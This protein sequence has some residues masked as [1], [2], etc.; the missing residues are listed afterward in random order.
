MMK[1]TTTTSKWTRRDLLVE[2]AKA[3]Q[4]LAEPVDYALETDRW[5]QHVPNVQLHDA[6]RTSTTHR[7]D[8]DECASFL[9]IKNDP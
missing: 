7:W 9:N 4:Q 6:G 1:C 5:N 3:L 8:L 2:R